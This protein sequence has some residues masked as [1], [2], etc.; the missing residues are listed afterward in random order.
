MINAM[1]K[2]SILLTCILITQFSFSQKA[3]D[4]FI[5]KNLKED[6][7]MAL[8][9]PGWLFESTLKLAAKMEDD[10]EFKEYATLA[11]YVKNIRVF[12]AKE[13][14]NIPESTVQDLIQKMVHNEGYDEYIRVRSKGT[15][16]NMF[17]I[18]EDDMIKRLVFFIDDSDETFVMLRLKLKLPYDAFKKL[19]YKL[20][21]EITP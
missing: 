15:N 1:K 11:E 3:V 7:T 13:N 8:S 18:E 2:L 5:S 6:H 9:F 20:N 4:K 19:N 17:A 12:V 16:V 10:E 14:H 21:E